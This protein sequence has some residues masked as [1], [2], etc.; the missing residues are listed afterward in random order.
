M[1]SEGPSDETEMYIMKVLRNEDDFGNGAANRELPRVGKR[2]V[3]PLFTEDE[4]SHEVFLDSKPVLFFFFFFSFFFLFFSLFFSFSLFPFHSLF[5][6]F[7][8]FFIP[9]I[10]L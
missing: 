4:S 2:N 7:S 3:P 8:L 5:S 9:S 10:F 1:V 6:L